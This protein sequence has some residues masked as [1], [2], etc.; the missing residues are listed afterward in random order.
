VGRAFP[1]RQGGAAGLAENVI[2]T[3]AALHPGNSGGALCDGAAAAVG[4]NTAV[5]G[6][7]VG[8]GLG[9]A[10]PVNGVTRSLVCALMKGGRVRRA[11][12]GSAGGS[13]PLPPRA[14]VAAGRTHGFEVVE[15]VPGSPAADAGMRSEDMI[16]E[17]DG[18]PVTEAGGIQGLMT[19]DRI[20]RRVTLRM[21][22]QGAGRELIVELRELNVGRVWLPPRG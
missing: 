5:V 21:A 4:I 17:L 15:V 22:R 8:R 2:W 20:G 14:A 18:F 13:R 6:P 11:Y 9:L 7:Q 10:M 19:V 16:I 1:T 12:L 3:D